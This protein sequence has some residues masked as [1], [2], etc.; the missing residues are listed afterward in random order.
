M[1]KGGFTEAELMAANWSKNFKKA[2]KQL[3]TVSIFSP[4]FAKDNFSL[5][6]SV[7]MPTRK[8]EYKK[9]LNQRKRRKMNGAKKHEGKKKKI[10]ES[11]R[12]KLKFLAVKRSSVADF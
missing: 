3:I 10:K 11:T 9:M 2:E 5:Q 12:K 4:L 6:G 7:F 1:G 8:L